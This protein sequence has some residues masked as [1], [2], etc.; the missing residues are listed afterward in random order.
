MVPALVTNLLSLFPML[1]GDEAAPGTDRKPP[2]ACLCLT[3]AVAALWGLPDDVSLTLALAPWRYQ[4]EEGRARGQQGPRSSL[5][6]VPRSLREFLGRTT[7][8][9]EGGRDRRQA[10]ADGTEAGVSWG[11]W[12]S[13]QSPGFRP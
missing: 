9:A 11:V 13:A 12:L 3:A 4:G 2:C 6:W 7:D 1:R 8:K 10:L 5:P